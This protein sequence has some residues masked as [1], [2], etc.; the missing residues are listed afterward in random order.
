MF[1][2][3]R[4]AADNK[5]QMFLP[6]L[7]NDAS[8]RKYPGN[9]KVMI[10]MYIEA[11]NAKIDMYRHFLMFSSKFLPYRLA[12]RIPPNCPIP[13]LSTHVNAAAPTF[14]VVT[15]LPIAMNKACVDKNDMA[16]TFTDEKLLKR[17]NL[18]YSLDTLSG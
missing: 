14:A 8:N 6:M 1:K 3:A 12:N 10:S 15:V 5:K 16:V 11:F 18:R 13:S 2:E 4:D 17:V 9:F 7:A